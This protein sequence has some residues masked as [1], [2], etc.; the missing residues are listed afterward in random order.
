[1]MIF[2]MTAQRLLIKC[3]VKKRLSLSKLLKI[4]GDDKRLTNEHNWAFIRWQRA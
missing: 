1:M 4:K 2:A 3:L